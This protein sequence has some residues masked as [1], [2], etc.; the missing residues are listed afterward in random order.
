M[1]KDNLL[2]WKQTEQGYFIDR[3]ACPC[4]F[5]KEVN[6]PKMHFNAEVAKFKGPPIRCTDCKKHVMV[7]FVREWDALMQNPLTGAYVRKRQ[8]PGPIGDK[9]CPDYQLL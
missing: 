8:V 2:G 4:G 6:S 9:T 3:Y 7:V 5:Q 1:K